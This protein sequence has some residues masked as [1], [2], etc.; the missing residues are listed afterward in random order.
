MAPIHEAVL[1]NNL[2][3]V[4]QLVMANPTTTDVH[5]Y[6]GRPLYIAASRG[7]GHIAECLLDHGADINARNGFDDQTALYVACE[8][9][10]EVVVDLL[11][12]RGADP[13]IA[14]IGITPLM[15]A[16]QCGHLGAASAL[17]SDV[18]GRKLL[19]AKDD[20]G[21]TLLMKVCKSSTIFWRPR[22]RFLSA[23]TH[24]LENCAN[25]FIEDQ[26]HMTALDLLN[27]S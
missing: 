10:H 3:L 19:N 22:Y 9:G 13:I 16:Y 24:L 20:L 2:D 26:H 11:L 4:E 12:S 14:S 15:R 23:I 25:P 1:G 18:E 5:D 27:E 6:Y 7:L 17:L 8:R 21:M